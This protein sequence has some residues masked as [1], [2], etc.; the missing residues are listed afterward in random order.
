MNRQQLD[1]QDRLYTNLSRLENEL[2]RIES[3]NLAQVRVAEAKELR[4]RIAE[5]QAQLKG[6]E[7]PLAP[8]EDVVPSE[9]VA[10]GLA[11]GTDIETV[12]KP[13]EDRA[14]TNSPYSLEDPYA[15]WSEED[16]N[17]FWED[18]AFGTLPAVNRVD[19]DTSDND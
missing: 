6:L 10:I 16:W 8:V 9:E 18:S 19:S 17:D 13:I 3:G 5:L 15:D 1:E 12:F 11:E 7:P 2:W 14:T 4:H